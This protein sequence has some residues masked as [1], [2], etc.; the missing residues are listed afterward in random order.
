MRTD[1][2]A[3]A[4][5]F[6]SKLKT[7]SRIVKWVMRLQEFSFVVQYMQCKENVVADALSRIPWPMQ[8][9][10]SDAANSCNESDSES[11]HELSDLLPAFDLAMPTVNDL[12]PLTLE[13]ISLEQGKDDN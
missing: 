4:A 2:A 9:I 11:E 1:H 3:L 13:E 10:G 6:T 5:I 12:P 8:A 7:S